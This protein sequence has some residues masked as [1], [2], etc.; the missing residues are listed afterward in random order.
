MKYTDL[1]KEY[2]WLVNTIAR[3]NG[4]TL[5]EIN[6]HWLKTDMS[7]GIKLA[8]STFNRHKNAIEDIFGIYIECDRNKG[9]RYY[10]GNAHDLQEDTIQNWMLSTMTVNNLL[11]ENKS[12]HDRVLLETIPSM[13]EQLAVLMEAM[14]ANRKVG[15]FYQ[16]YSGEPGKERTIAPYCV[17]LYRRRWYVVAEID[18]G[19]I[20]CFSLDRI[21][22]IHTTDE[23]FAMPEGFCAAT[24]FADVIG[25]MTTAEEKRQRIVIRAYYQEPHYLRDLP[26]HHSQREINSTDEY[27]DFEYKLIP[28]SD[29]IRHLFSR[30]GLERVLEPQWLADQIKEMHLSSARMYENP[31]VAY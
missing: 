9:Y 24:H 11:T 18:N 14:K 28:T 17:K 12:L 29:F 10:I 21:L 2:V 4:I 31:Y 23:T 6:A 25:V 13:G 7:G 27:T 3:R 15:I 26:I 1:F 30:G 20:R 16:K 22:E 5:E 19:E 8:R